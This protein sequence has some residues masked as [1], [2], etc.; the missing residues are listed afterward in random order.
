MYRVG[1]MRMPEMRWSSTEVRRR[2]P[3]W[4]GSALL[5]RAIALIVAAGILAASAVARAQPPPE[6]GAAA[7]PEEELV[8]QDS[9]RASLSR[10][11]DL[12]RAG[13]YAEAARYLDLTAAQRPHGP[14]LA[15]KLKAVLDRHVWIDLED[16]SPLPGGNAGDGLR[17]GTDEVAHIPGATGSPEPVRVVRRSAGGA[18]WVFSRATVNRIGSW[19]DRLEHRWA[20][21]YLPDVLLRPGPRDLL[22]WQWL[23]FPV[24]LLVSWGLGYV[25]TRLTRHLLGRLASRTPTQ[26]DDQML[27]QMTGPF[28]FAWALG[29]TFV[30]VPWLGL[31]QPAQEFMDRLTRAAFFVVFFWGLARSIDVGRD[32][33]T[34]STPSGQHAASRSLVPLGAR[35]AKLLVLAIAVVAFLSQLGYPVASLV[36]GLG[37]GGLAVALAAQKSLE[38]LF[39]TFSLGAD[40]P[41]REGDFVRVEDFVGTVETIGLRSSR[42]RTLDRTL[43]TIPN[44]K[45]AEMRLESFT[46]RDR[47]RLACFIRLVH[48]TT[49]QQMRAVLAGLERVLREHPK[50]WTSSM[51]VRLAELAESSLNVEVMAWFQTPDWDEFQL[52]RQEVLLQ[53][54]A[55]VEESGSSFAFPTRT[56]H[57]TG[58]AGSERENE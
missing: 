39:G 41:F 44:G 4:A 10:F 52:I 9:P 45:L 47:M 38:N 54:M 7:E 27:V 53:F 35:V 22:Y 51:V 43:I 46:A 2:A 57:L 55:V 20:L 3:R 32:V 13:E 37:I 15:W 34:A 26:W 11:F 31:Y 1:T 28:T 5:Y 14:D 25:L 42:I 6:A 48:G 16:V 58:G 29:V 23:A 19:Y 8:A 12:C 36:A 17:R 50:I 21:E 18:R 24:L 56:V 49:A 30:L 40:Q 33:I